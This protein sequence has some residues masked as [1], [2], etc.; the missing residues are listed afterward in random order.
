MSETANSAA[1]HGALPAQGAGGPYGLTSDLFERLWTIDDFC[2]FAGV[3]ERKSR[4]LLAQKGAPPPLRMGSERCVRW[5]PAQVVAWLH[6]DDWRS[7]GVVPDAAP[8][9]AVP[10]APQAGLV[11]VVPD[12]PDAAVRRGRPPGGRFVAPSLPAA[13][14]GARR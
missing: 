3:S 13:G 9:L 4:A 2:G 14:R 7:L 12:A 10:D 6:G 5:N 11:R 8:P 1:A